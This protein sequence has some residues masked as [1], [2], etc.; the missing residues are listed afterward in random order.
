MSLVFQGGGIYASGLT[1]LIL[2]S[3]LALGGGT[4]WFAAGYLFVAAV[5]STVAALKA[6]PHEQL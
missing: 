3:L 5:V 4:P 1:P 2:T 6:R